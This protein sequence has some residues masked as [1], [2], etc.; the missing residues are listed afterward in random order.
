MRLVG[1]FQLVTGS[2]MLGLWG[3]LVATDQVAELA[4]GRVDIL[5][6]LAAEVI[7]A[8]LLIV[9]GLGLL[10]SATAAARLLAGF[11]LGALLYTT[12]NSAGYY[13]ELGDR[14]MVI[15]FAVLALATVGAFAALR[16][17]GSAATDPSL[18]R[19]PTGTGTPGR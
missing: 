17:D 12:V 4:E 11:G 3:M 13:A 18:R 6:H 19:V 14:P 10:R 5:F 9:G 8:A 7:T 16:R 15:M 1:W 2:A